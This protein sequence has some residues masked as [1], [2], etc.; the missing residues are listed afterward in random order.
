MELRENPDMRRVEE[1][2]GQILFFCTK[3]PELVNLAVE[4]LSELIKNVS[5]L[6]EPQAMIEIEKHITEQRNKGHV[7]NLQMKDY[8]LAATILGK[9][10][11]IPF[12]KKDFKKKSGVI[13]W[14]D[15][16]WSQLRVPFFMVIDEIQNSNKSPDFDE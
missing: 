6:I 1:S 2:L 11:H 13:R 5:L 9:R 7:I 12:N 4:K 3:K 10:C 16:N 14:L 8:R 15:K